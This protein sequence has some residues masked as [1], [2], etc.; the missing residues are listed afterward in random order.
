[1][2]PPIFEN[3]P[4]YVNLLDIDHVSDPSAFIEN[5][6][7]VSTLD[8]VANQVKLG[9]TNTVVPGRLLGRVEAYEEAGASEY[10]KDTVRWGYKLVFIDNKPPPSNYRANNRSALSNSV[11]LL[12]ELLRLESL[13]C[14]KRVNSRPHIVNPC[15]IVYSKKWRCVLS[16]TQN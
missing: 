8:S 9:D 15:S 1:M 10:I 16:Q 3:D 5:S 14:T 6:I 7:L 13:G 11:F 4:N 12:E 2:A